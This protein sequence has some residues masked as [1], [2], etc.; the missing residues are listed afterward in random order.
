MSEF[1]SPMLRSLR[2]L[3]LLILVILMLPAW[4]SWIFL[5]E[6]RQVSALKM[7]GELRR[8]AVGDFH[9]SGV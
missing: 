5:S 1:V 8:W 3:P 7:V 4:L 6:K 9:D 2:Y